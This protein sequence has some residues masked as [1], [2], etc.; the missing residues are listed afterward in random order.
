MQEGGAW[1][2]WE[3]GMR[4]GRGRKGERGREKGREKEGGRKGGRRETMDREKVEK[5]RE[6]GKHPLY[7]LYSGINR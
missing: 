6:K 3:D 7:T 4:K 5:G 2:G 1:C